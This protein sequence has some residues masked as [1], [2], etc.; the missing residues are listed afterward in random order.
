MSIPSPKLTY[1]CWSSGALISTNIAVEPDGGR[2]VTLFSV[3]EISASTGR[4]GRLRMYARGPMRKRDGGR[5]PSRGVRVDITAEQPAWLAAI[6]VDAA[7]RLALVVP[8]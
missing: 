2:P 5:G 7:A 3:H 8:S 6:V 4:D 1:S